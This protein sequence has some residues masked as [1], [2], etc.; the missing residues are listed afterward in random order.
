MPF[1]YKSYNKKQRSLQDRNS[2]KSKAQ[3][4]TNI[5]KYL[6]ILLQP[7]SSG[8]AFCKKRAF[9]FSSCSG[10]M[11]V[12]AGLILPFFLMAVLML[13]NLFH[14]C[15][16]YQELL[17]AGARSVHRCAVE[18]YDKDFGM[19]SILEKMVLQIGRSDADFSRISGGMAGIDYW[20]TGYDP[21][22]GKIDAVLSCNVLP[23]FSLFSLGN[24]KVSFSLHSRAFIGG[25]ML[26]GSDDTAAT[27]KKMVYVAENGVVY[28][29]SRECAYID[30]S[31]HG[32][33]S[34]SL[35]GLRNTQGGKYYP[36]E[37]CMESEDGGGSVVYITDTGTRYH[38][39]SQCPGLS[40]TV[41]EME[42]TLD[43]GLPP[44]HRCQP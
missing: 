22:S 21:D 37:R 29:S 4:I 1:F 6:Y 10:L 41:Y 8:K 28:H 3:A 2:V 31:L 39:S 23:A 36:C 5:K 25:K 27:D 14:V 15:G 26:S 11:T 17:A 18:G 43:C 34:G 19:D 40:R 32:V 44:C 9:R 30:L 35:D 7:E 20:G 16:I 13:L 38:S 42:L 33:M 12:E 24:I